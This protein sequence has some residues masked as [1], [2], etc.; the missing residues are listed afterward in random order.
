MLKKAK[1]KKMYKNKIINKSRL[2][3]WIDEFT[4]NNYNK[5]N[6]LQLKGK[7]KL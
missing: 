7:N 3:Y 1:Y 4:W 6:L 5:I 2:I